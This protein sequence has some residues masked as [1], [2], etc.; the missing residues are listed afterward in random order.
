[1]AITVD[2]GKILCRYPR[3]PILQAGRMAHVVDNEIAAGPQ[4]SQRMDIHSLRPTSSLTSSMDG[5]QT[6]TPKWTKVFT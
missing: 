2:I 6:V 1:M 3:Q 5:L 4:K